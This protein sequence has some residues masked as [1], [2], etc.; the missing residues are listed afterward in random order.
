VRRA[1][2]EA[3]G[4]SL[5]GAA[6]KLA[7]EARRGF[8]FPRMKIPASAPPFPPLFGG[9][10]LP[11]IVAFTI[12]ATWGN[13]LRHLAGHWAGNPQ[14]AYGWSVPVLMAMLL[15]RAWVDRPPARPENPGPTSLALA[16]VLALAAL[17]AELLLGV[18][19]DWRLA[20]WTLAGSVVGLTLVGVRWVGGP[21]WVRHFAIP[22]AFIFLAVPWP[23]A[24][25]LAVI[26]QLTDLAAT[27]TVAVLDL[28]GTPV[29][30]HG[31]VLEIGAGS[32]GVEAACSGVRS[33]QG[34]LMISV[35]LGQLR[36]FAPGR[37]MLL[38]AIGVLVAFVGNVARA[39]LLA[40]VAD[41]D[42]LAAVERWHDPTG[43]AVLGFGVVMLALITARWPRGVLSP[44]AP[45]DGGAPSPCGRRAMVAVGMWMVCVIVAVE[46][47]YR[48]ASP[49][50]VPWWRIEWPVERSHFT[51]V[52]TEEEARALQFD[53]G[54]GASWSERDGSE[55][56]VFFFRWHPGGTTSRMLARFHQPTVC[57]PASGL[58][59]VREG[60]SFI[61]REAGAELRF[62]DYLFATADRT[63]RVFYCV[64]EDRPPAL[65][66][67]GVP[68]AW[69]PRERFRAVLRRQRELGQQTLEIGITGLADDA[70]ARAKFERL[71]RP[72]LR[73]DAAPVSP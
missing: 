28:C 21:A 45:A 66:D 41:R 15:W 71:L 69:T 16:S 33:F 2:A 30:R 44:E 19:P 47:W 27:G 39:S 7:G 32:L 9:T 23:V 37:R 3:R 65:A 46:L 55:W 35:F 61:I 31:D 26:R 29:V 22:L 24:V 60:P 38:V 20:Q 70:E 12:F 63:M 8:V 51:T 4:I 62:H 10:G 48:T 56:T 6:T 72:L 67:A 14:Y 34:M 11:W 13:L 53:E 5:T 50:A 73:P 36:R 42:G 17:P 43:F 64:W 40:W 18:T 54:G 57:L 68:G 25:E 58:R 1:S 49:V 52:P 59:L